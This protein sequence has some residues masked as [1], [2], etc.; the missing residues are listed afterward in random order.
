MFPNKRP[1]FTYTFQYVREG[2]TYTNQ[3]TSSLPQE[4]AIRA[5]QYTWGT[6]RWTGEIDPNFKILSIEPTK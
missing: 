4:D 5:L 1:T 3:S 6:C 2:A